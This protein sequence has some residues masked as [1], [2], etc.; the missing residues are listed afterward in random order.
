MRK[1]IEAIPTEE[2]TKEIVMNSGQDP[3][4]KTL[5]ISWNST[6]DVFTVTSFAVS[7]G[8]LYTVQGRGRP[9]QKR[10]LCLFTCLETR[11][12]HFRDGLGT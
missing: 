6:E 5:G 7:A 4:T 10:W 12:V 8:P 1:A 2:R 9:R 11:A 3:I